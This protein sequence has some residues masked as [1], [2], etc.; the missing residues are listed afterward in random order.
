MDVSV[1][2]STLFWEKPA[3]SVSYYVVILSGKN[4]EQVVV[5][6]TNQYY[7][8]SEDKKDH[9]VQVYNFC[10]VHVI[11]SGDSE[12]WFLKIQ[13]NLLL[14]TQCIYMCTA[15]CLHNI[16]PTDLWCCMN[17]GMCSGEWCSRALQY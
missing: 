11:C 13:S 8:I 6:T 16:L 10:M 15:Y 12:K 4:N 2:G 3:G 17:T 14:Q 5:N 9:S 7:K 1:D